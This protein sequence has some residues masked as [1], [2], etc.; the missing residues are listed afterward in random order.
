MALFLHNCVVFSNHS[1]G[2]ASQKRLVLRKNS[3]FSLLQINF[4]QL[5]LIEI[6]DATKKDRKNRFAN[7]FLNLDINRIPDYIIRN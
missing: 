7:I 2:Y 4:K 6:M 3:S 1:Y 5:Q